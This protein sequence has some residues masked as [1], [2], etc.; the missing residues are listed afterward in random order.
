MKPKLLDLFCGA[1]GCSMGY[2]RAGFDVTGV[3][4][5]PQPH[6]PF[7]FHQADALTFPLE[8]FD[9]IH[10]SPPCQAWSVASELHRRAGKKYQDC[11]TPIRERLRSRGGIWVIENVPR[12]PIQPYAIQLCGLMF[13]LKVFRHRLFQLSHLIPPPL[14]P[15]HVGLRVGD[16]YFSV[17]GSGGRWKSWGTV[18]RNVSKGTREEWRAAMGI[19]WMTRHEL[20]QSIPPAYTEYI[21][22]WLIEFIGSRSNQRM[23]RKPA[24]TEVGL[25]SEDMREKR[26]S[27]IV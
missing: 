11:L 22:K 27:S 5:A 25:T 6:Y 21:G 2:Q 12:A 10:A 23:N 4:I 13:G 15:S 3:D 16:G 9:A 20:T 8:G 19:P 14:H 7:E 26:I 24:T 18:H 17:A 1:G